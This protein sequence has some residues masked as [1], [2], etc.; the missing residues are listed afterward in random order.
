VIKRQMPARRHPMPQL[1]FPLGLCLLIGLLAGCHASRPAHVGRSATSAGASHLAT[2]AGVGE[3]QLVAPPEHGAGATPMFRWNAVSGADRYQ[4]F[5]RDAQGQPIWAWQGG[6]T[7]VRLGGL[8]IVAPAGAAGP[9]LTAGATWLVLALAN[10]G[11][12][13]A[14]SAVRAVNP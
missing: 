1:A 2:P 3:V 13:R 12:V 11:G 4:L 9:R 6:D 14:V 5:V 8:S 7:S 10:D